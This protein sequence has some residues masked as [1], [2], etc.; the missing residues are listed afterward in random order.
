MRKSL[1]SKLV[2]TAL[3]AGLAVH[4]KAKDCVVGISMY[5]LAAPYFVAQEKSAKERATELGCKVIAS[6]DARND[7]NKQIAD[8]EDMVTKGVNLLVL[9]PR[10]PGG[11]RGDDP[12]VPANLTAASAASG[13]ATPSRTQGTTQ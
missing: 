9:N 10:A 13:A 12:E 2:L 11:A 4:A 8:V 7:M 5:T 3:L 6:A 1:C